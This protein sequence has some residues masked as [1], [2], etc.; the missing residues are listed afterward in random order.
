MDYGRSSSIQRARLY[1]GSDRISLIRWYPAAPGAKVFPGWHAF[2]HPAWEDAEERDQ[3]TGPGAFLSGQEWVGNRYPAPPGQHFHGPADW[4]LD[5]I[6]LEEFQDEF[7]VS[8]CGGP[9]A[10]GAGGVEVGGNSP[11]ATPSIL[12]CAVCTQGAFNR[13][14]VRVRGVQDG[15]KPASD[16]NGDH[17]VSYVSACTWQGPMVPI[18]GFP[19]VYFWQLVFG[20]VATR[21]QL[22]RVVGTP[23]TLT[24]WDVASPRCFEPFTE[25]FTSGNAA[26]DWTNATLEV[27]PYV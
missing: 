21:V 8:T 25:S 9:I 20:N 17:P 7:P 10:V 26:W 27:I 18:T 16:I 6:P 22:R 3:F 11:F 12:T 15:T 14:L 23:S 1:R 24:I 19:L 4:F 13:Y 5:G 2:G